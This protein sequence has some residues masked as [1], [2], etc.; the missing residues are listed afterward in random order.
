MHN[1][2]EPDIRPQCTALAI[3]MIQMLAPGGITPSQPGPPGALLM[4]T[5][6]GSLE[7][8]TAFREGPMVREH[9]RGVAEALLAEVR[10]LADLLPIGHEDA[11]RL[12]G[13][14][15][16]LEHLLEATE[17][18]RLMP[19]DLADLEAQKSLPTAPA[20]GIPA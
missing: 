7:D 16:S 10:L 12:R 4:G 1:H 13:L 6:I 5:L 18:H 17:T 11:S 2:T 3:K 14:R 9:D 20:G 8:L 15:N 19:L